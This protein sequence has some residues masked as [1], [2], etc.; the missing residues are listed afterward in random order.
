MQTIGRSSKAL[1]N[2]LDDET[3]SR[4]L[5]KRRIGPKQSKLVPELHAGEGVS[6]RNVKAT[7]CDL[8]DGEHWPGDSIGRPR[9]AD[10]KM[11]RSS[12]V[13]RED[14]VGQETSRWRAL[15]LRRLRPIPKDRLRL[16]DRQDL[17]GHRAGRITTHYSADE[18]S[19]LIEAAN[20]VC[21][22][23]G[24]RQDLVVLR[25]LSIS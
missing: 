11:C 14:V 1:S 5:F 18:L 7:S 8:H 4:I 19:H 22:R 3:S 12:A 21:D 17:L 23:Q 9:S 13:T 6:R 20:S 2:T 24:V 16:L 15:Q 10:M 25:R